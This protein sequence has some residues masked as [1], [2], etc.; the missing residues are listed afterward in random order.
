MKN[1]II[2]NKIIVYLLMALLLFM[3]LFLK[4]LIIYFKILGTAIIVY[5]GIYFSYSM[6]KDEPPPETP[7]TDVPGDILKSLSV[8]V[9]SFF[10]KYIVKNDIDRLLFVTITNDKFNIDYD[11]GFADNDEFV[12]ER[13]VIYKAFRED[14]SVHFTDIEGYKTVICNVLKNKGGKIIAAIFIGNIR[15]Y[16]IIDAINT[17]KFMAQVLDVAN[18]VIKRYGIET[19][20]KMNLIKKYTKPRKLN[21]LELTPSEGNN[22]FFILDTMDSDDSSSLFFY[23]SLDEPADLTNVLEQIGFVKYSIKNGGSLVKTREFLDKN[24]SFLVKNSFFAQYIADTK[25]LSFQLSGMLY[26]YKKSKNMLRL[27]LERSSSR[28]ENKAFDVLD[29]IQLVAEDNIFIT[30]RELSE[31]E[32]IESSFDPSLQYLKIVVK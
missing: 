20:V 15:K 4:D 18:A 28:L 23:S 9:R 1:K 7:P 30:S 12:F 3:I 31:K 10:H 22:Q 6:E 27:R 32:L 8:G 11:S 29:Q 5:I 19:E 26:L 13:K 2:E 16:L 25:L 21:K 14:I 17:E 24:D